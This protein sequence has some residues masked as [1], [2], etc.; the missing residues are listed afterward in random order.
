MRR[1]NQ[2]SPVC[3]C[4]RQDQ[5][6]NGVGYSPH[7]H[8]TEPSSHILHPSPWIWRLCVRLCSQATGTLVHRGTLYCNPMSSVAETQSAITQPTL[9]WPMFSELERERMGRRKGWWLS[10]GSVITHSL[11]SHSLYLSV[12]TLSLSL[13][14]HTLSISVITLSLS[15]SSHSLYHHTLSL[16]SHSI[17]VITHYISPWQ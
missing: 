1:L 17:S 7:P 8:K 13:C 12:I 16:S 4:Y 2:Y 10:V 5:S 9:N 14:H 11:S 3:A 6:T 15:L